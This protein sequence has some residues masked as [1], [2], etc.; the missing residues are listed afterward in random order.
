MKVPVVGMDLDDVLADFIK[1]F[2]EIAHEKY[3]VDPS[4]RPTSWEWDDVQMT[5]EMVKGVWEVI[6]ATEDFWE[7]LDV[8]EGVEPR[9]IQKLD[10]NVKLYFPTARAFSAGDD[11]GK[12][13]ARWINEHFEIGFPTVIV[14]SEKGEMAKVLKYDYFVDDRPKNCLDIKAA[15]PDCK[16]FLVN[17]THNHAFSD[18]RIPRIPNVNYFV[19]KV[20]HETKKT[21]EVA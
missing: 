18:P 5:A 6:T 13:S 8:I 3:G 15:L 2:M 10:D 4:L 1:K 17:A 20:L 9:L 11:V 12:Q 19:R 21:Q 14:S 16:V 7:T